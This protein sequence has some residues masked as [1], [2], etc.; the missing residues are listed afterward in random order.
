MNIVQNPAFICTLA[1]LLLTATN[2]EG[3]TTVDLRN[4]AIEDYPGKQ[5]VV[6][7]I[8]SLECG[9]KI[10][11]RDCTVR[12]ATD[13]MEVEVTFYEVSWWTCAK[14]KVG[15]WWHRNF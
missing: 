4:K 5:L 9:G 13:N 6:S 12:V 3:A 11:E 14:L 7:P 8:P 15:A 2:I 1:L 10:I